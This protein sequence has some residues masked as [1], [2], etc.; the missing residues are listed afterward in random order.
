MR[1]AANRG[2]T[3][4]VEIAPHIGKVDVAAV[5]EL[6]IVSLFGQLVGQA[7]Q[8]AATVRHFNERGGRQTH[9]SADDRD[10]ATVGAEIVGITVAEIDT[11]PAVAHKIGSNA[12]VH[13]HSF[14]ATFPNDEQDVGPL[15]REQRVG[16]G[17]VGGEKRVDDILGLLVGHKLELMLKILRLEE[18]VSHVK[19]RIQRSVVAEGIFREIGV[20]RVGGGFGDTGAHA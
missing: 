10:Y 12:V 18:R 7:R 3:R 11:L 4:F 14:S 20:G 16:D 9:P 17:H 1:A 13:S 5:R 19:E 6:G 8:F 2:E 15:A